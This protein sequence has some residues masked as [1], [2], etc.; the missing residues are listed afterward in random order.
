ML[1]TLGSAAGVGALLGPALGGVAATVGVSLT[2]ALV[3]GVGLAVALRA[4]FTP[5]PGP[6]PS[7][8]KLLA[9]VLAAVFEPRLVTGLLL[10]GFSPLLFGVLTVLAPLTLS[11]FGWGAAAIGASSSSQPFSKPPF[12]PS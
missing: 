3:C 10:I 5:A 7:G 8:D 9:A 2:F 12:I 6:S 1:G 11:G 4:W